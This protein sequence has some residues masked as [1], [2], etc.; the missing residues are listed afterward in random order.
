M[1][2]EFEYCIYNRNFNCIADQQRI[3]HL[4]CVIRV[5]FFR[6]IKNFLKKRRKGS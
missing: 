1:N 3:N 4:G 2:C 5:L 6:L